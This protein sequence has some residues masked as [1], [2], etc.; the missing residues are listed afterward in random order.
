[1]R[2]VRPAAVA[3][4]FLT[5][6]PLR[7]AEVGERDLGRSVAYFPVAGLALGA[8]VGAAAWAVRGHLAPA[9]QAAMLVAL[10]AWLTGGLHLDGLADVF[11]G[12]SGGHR[13]PARALA[14]MRDARIGAHGAAAL[15]LLLLA[16]AAAL[17][18]LL[19]RSDGWALI[20]FPVAARWA[21]VPLVV[22]FPYARPE[23]LGKAFHENA[24]AV[25]V[26]VATLLAA[27]VAI[28]MGVRAAAPIAAALAAALL[29]ALVV[30]RRLGGLTGDVY[31][32][33]IEL[34]E[35]A[36]LVAA[37]VQ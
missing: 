7:A 16:K 15:C 19:E 36:F 32:A 1:M 17:V 21:V 14:I 6:L 3:F 12:L 10:L 24:R 22:L 26:A 23:G 18:P 30:Q 9:V 5:R 27:P 35:L 34:S 13:D 4:G 33:C 2:A 11:D 28:S 31:G 29:F 25:Q 8:L 37:G 20:A